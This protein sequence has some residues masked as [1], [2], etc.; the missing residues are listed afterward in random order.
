MPTQKQ[1]HPGFRLQAQVEHRRLTGGTGLQDVGHVQR[2]HGTN[3]GKEPPLANL[4]DQRLA[5]RAAP[6]IGLGPDHAVLSR[7]IGGQVQVVLGRDARLADRQRAVQNHHPQRRVIDQCCQPLCKI[8]GHAVDDHRA[9]GT[10]MQHVIDQP[11]GHLQRAFLQPEGQKNVAPGQI[12]GFGGRGGQRQMAAAG[13]RHARARENPQRRARDG[14]QFDRLGR[15]IRALSETS[16]TKRRR[17]R[18]H[19]EKRARHPILA[20]HAIQK[21]ADP[22]RIA[23]LCRCPAPQAAISHPIF[24]RHAVVV[25]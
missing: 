5:H 2:Q 20:R 22:R 23:Q 15:I 18:A 11:F 9:L 24:V 14:A 21:A 4:V 17:R 12:V 16:R 6:W 8:P 7:R 19:A 25:P 3:A 10:V 13:Q 1:D